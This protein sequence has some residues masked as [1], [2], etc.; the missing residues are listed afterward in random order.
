MEKYA[1]FI[2]TFS[3]DPVSH[4][5]RKP[6]FLHIKKQKRRS[7]MVTAQLIRYIGSTISLFKIRNFKSLSLTSPVCVRPGQKPGRQVLMD[8]SQNALLIR[9]DEF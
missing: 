2:I 5:I 8:V 6:A 4:I 1:K 9:P 7:A 3:N